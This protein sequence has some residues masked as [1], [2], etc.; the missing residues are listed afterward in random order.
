MDELHVDF[1]PK[2]GFRVHTLSK[3][4]VDAAF[5]KFKERYPDKDERTLREEFQVILDGIFKKQSVINGAKVF[6]VSCGAQKRTLRKWHNSYLCVDC[7]KIMQN[8]GEE[9]F[10]KALRGEES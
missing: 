10:I 1:K 9:Q 4:S 6:C 8:V 2:R 5:E 7:W 3:E